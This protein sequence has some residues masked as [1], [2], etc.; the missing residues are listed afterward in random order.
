MQQQ[1]QQQ[2]LQQQRALEQ[3]RQQQMMQPEYQGQFAQQQQPQN[4]LVTLPADAVFGQV[5]QVQAPDGRMVNFQVPH[6]AGPGS[7][8]QVAL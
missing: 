6:G 5:Y 8:V 3:M 2:A 1:Q 7:E 4:M